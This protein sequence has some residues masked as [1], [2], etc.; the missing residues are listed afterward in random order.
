[1]N[2]DYRRNVTISSDLAS[3]YETSRLLSVTVG[4]F[5]ISWTAC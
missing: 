4:V 5:S 3:Y 2:T 1:M